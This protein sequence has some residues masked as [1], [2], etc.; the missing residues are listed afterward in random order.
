MDQEFSPDRKTP[1]VSV[2]I[3]FLNGEQ[4]LRE[5]IES[6][7]AQTYSHWELL[8][9]DDGSSDA[10]TQIAMRY[11][12]QNGEKVRYLDHD[13]HLNRGVCASRNLGI[14]QARGELIALLDVDDV[15][16]TEKL[17]R[18]V[19]ILSAK[20]EAAMV[21]GPSQYWYSWPENRQEDCQSDFIPNLGVEP[22]RLIRPPT[23][24]TLALESK[25]PTPCPSNILLRREIVDLVGGFEESFHGAHQLYEDQVFLAKVYLKAP[26]FVASECWDRYRQHPNSCVS[27]VTGAGQKY[28][29]GLSYLRWLEGYL[30]AEGIKDR[31]VW[32]ALEKKRMRYRFPRLAPLLERAQHH[33]ERIKKLVQPARGR[34]S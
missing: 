23:L 7:F 30:L 13:G 12:Q 22:N 1:L 10:S 6:V 25:A 29:T 18:Q 20:P 19:A 9:V 16:L 4:F 28:R 15:W 32:N 24:L 3:P 17:G 14:R 31:E 11:A 34:T 2:V 8:L 33:V 27:V 21:Y 5:A 26:V